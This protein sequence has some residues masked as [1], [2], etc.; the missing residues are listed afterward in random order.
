MPHSATL[1]LMDGNGH[2]STTTFDTVAAVPE[3]STWVML[4]VAF[5]GL[6]VLAY[7]RR[8]QASKPIATSPITVVASGQSFGAY[9]GQNPPDRHGMPEQL[10]ERK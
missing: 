8:K 6:S 1:L 10:A 7:R 2:F 4:I 5:C 3:P 9:P